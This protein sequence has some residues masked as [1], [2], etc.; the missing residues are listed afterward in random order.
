MD[1]VIILIYLTLFCCLFLDM[2]TKNKKRGGEK[3]NLGRLWGRG[4]GRVGK[5]VMRLR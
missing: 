3:S 5:S 1:P 4:F 2:N